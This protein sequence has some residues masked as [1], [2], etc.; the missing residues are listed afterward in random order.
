[1][2]AL[3]KAFLNVTPCCC[4][5]VYPGMLRFVHPGG[6]CWSGALLVGEEQEDVHPG[7]LRGASLCRPV[8]D[9]LPPTPRHVRPA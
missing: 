8:S 3:V 6:K 5:R 1:M 9:A 7:Y 2:Q 4:R